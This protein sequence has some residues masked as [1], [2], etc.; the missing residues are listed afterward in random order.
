MSTNQQPQQEV[1]DNARFVQ[2]LQSDD[3]HKEVIGRW[4]LK[5]V[6]KRPA[7]RRYLFDLW[8]RRHFIWADSRARA[9]STGRGMILGNVWLVL[10]PLLNG[11]IYFLIFGVLLG[12]S[13]GID[14][15]VGYLIIGVF[16]FQFTGRSL[17]S[18]A[19]AITGS[20]AMIR[21]FTF[22]RA[23]L[24]ISIILREALNMLPVIGT[25]LLLI[26]MVPSPDAAE[27]SPPHADVTWRWL[28]FPAVFILQTVFNVGVAFFAARI[29]A[30][31]PD[32]RHLL[33]FVQRLWFYGSGVLY[34]FDRFVTDPQ[35][36]AI[37]GLNPVFIVLDM[38]RDLLLYGVSPEARS[39]LIL[40]AWAVGTALLGF[41]YFW[42]AEERYGRE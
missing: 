5:P 33:Q 19:T 4:F 25:M 14:R 22:P 23:S 36:L 29:V 3:P 20:K 1:Q 35:I 9:F 27:M 11:A 17:T 39:W 28:L 18:G 13:R 16:L 30:Q 37:L 6:G 41:I 32:F 34:S 8:N 2:E 26:V 12:T 7:L 21:G 31:I 24:P 40:G 15:F 42:R 10:Q 38:S